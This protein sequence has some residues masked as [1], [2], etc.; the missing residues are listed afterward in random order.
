[1]PSFIALHSYQ[2]ANGVA[3]AES[4]TERGDEDFRELARLAG[5]D[6]RDE[7]FEATYELSQLQVVP[8]AIFQASWL[9][10]L[11][12]FFSFFPVAS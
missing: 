6:L 9:P 12:I 1:M 3:M 10:F 2:I 8:H 7:A 5:A 11:N 4:G